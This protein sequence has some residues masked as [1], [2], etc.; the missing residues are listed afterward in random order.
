M[1]EKWKVIQ[2]PI[3][4]DERK[5][6]LRLMNRI[7]RFIIEFT[8]QN[9]L[10]I[11]IDNFHYISNQEFELIDHL[12]ESKKQ[13][14]LAILCTYREDLF[15]HQVEIQNWITSGI[16]EKL[17]MNKFNYSEAAEMIAGIL[18]VGQRPMELTTKIMTEAMG[19]PKYIEEVIKKSLYV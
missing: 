13:L 3:L 17:T 2:S 4:S 12:M 7:L 6:E 11:F 19:N 15:Q 16:V 1:S 10:I 9:P 18:G 5:E 14:P 8:S